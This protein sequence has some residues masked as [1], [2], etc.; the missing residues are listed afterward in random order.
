M[1]NPRNMINVRR[2]RMRIGVRSKLLV[3][4]A[5]VFL[6]GVSSIG[7]FSVVQ[8]HKE[9]I[10]ASHEKLRSD[11]QL[12]KAYLNEKIPGEWSI[13]DGNLYKGN[14]KLNDNFTVIDEIGLLTGDTVTIFQGNKRVAT[15]VK[16]DDGS[17]A[18]GTTV[19]EN[20][21]QV[22]LKDGQV[23]YGQANVVGTI[24][25]A[26]YEPIKNSIGEVI[27]IWYVGVPNTPYDQMVA[28][29]RN[30]IIALGFAELLI[31]MVILWFIIGRSLR[32][33][34][35]VNESIS[36]IAEGDLRSERLI[37]NSKDEISQMANGVNSMTEYLNNLVKQLI[38]RSA[39]LGLM[40]DTLSSS[41]E[42]IYTQ[43]Q[44]V[45]LTSQEIAAGMEEN[46]A[47]SE[48]VTASSQAIL[49]LTDKLVEK[50]NMGF[51]NAKE[52]N[53]RAKRTRDNARK[54]VENT[55]QI[56]MEKQTDI[57]NAI[58]E[59]K[60]V[61]KIENMAGVISDIA[62]QTNLLALNAA[63]EAARAGELGRGFSVVAEEVRKLAEESSNTVSDIKIVVRQVQDAFSKLTGN[64]EDV[65]SFIDCNVKH[66]YQEMIDIGLQYEQDAD[67][68]TKLVQDFA[69]NAEQISI[70]IGQ[71]IQ[72]IE[73]V[74]ASTQ[75]VATNTQNISSA[76]DETTK[77]IEGLSE[78]KEKQ[79]ALSE[80]LISL[81]Q[82]FKV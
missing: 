18:I 80:N 15:N 42:N 31:A 40:N 21:E 35:K 8:F 12:G 72:T 73:T 78:I 53:E 63:I 60:V 59:G 27:G 16:K 3:F 51:E 55:N 46:S 10:N 19:A 65:L 71:I 28:K 26:A 2:K 50:V 61:Q 36:Q 57:L 58:E 70:S 23:Y 41:V 48:E 49:D 22:V 43:T 75:Q 66:D 62:A 34:Q 13:K 52:I 82:R 39:Q 77:A 45:N 81:V 47:A 20:I 74:A 68:V 29:V 79:N 32:L 5:V 25:Q 24:N 56:F 44:S 17:R 11:L 33:L 38:E 37:A 69:T 7:A 76:I 1:S 6:I 14:E 54:S 64:A 9:V 30:S 67:F 4:V